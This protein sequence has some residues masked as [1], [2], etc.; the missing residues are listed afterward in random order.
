VAEAEQAGGRLSHSLACHL[1]VGIGSI[2]ARK[3]APAGK[4]NSPAADREGNNDPIADRKVSDFGSEFDHLAHIFMT[5][6]VAAL[7]G[8]LIA[9]QKMEVGTA[10]RAGRDFNKRVARMLNFGIGYSVDPHI[11]FTLPAKCSH[12]I[13]LSHFGLYWGKL[14][15]ENRF[16]SVEKC[17]HALRAVYFGTE[18]ASDER[19]CNEARALGKGRDQA[20]PPFFHRSLIR[21][22][23]ASAQRT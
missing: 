12:C 4:T 8:R 23:L 18:Q 14:R 22:L 9:V 17:K 5:E 21:R 13:C 19:S 10:D 16:R 3:K 2:T 6:N 7:H 11:P 20:R 15:N 1:S